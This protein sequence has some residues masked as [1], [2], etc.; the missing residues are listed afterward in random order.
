MFGKKQSNDLRSK[1]AQQ[2]SV[3]F[4]HHAFTVMAT[5]K[6][7]ESSAERIVIRS[8]PRELFLS[9]VQHVMASEKPTAPENLLMTLARA[10]NGLKD[11]FK[12][13]SANTISQ[14]H[15]SLVSVAREY[16]EDCELVH[17]SLLFHNPSV[18]GGWHR[19]ILARIT[20]EYKKY[21]IAKTTIERGAIEATAQAMPVS[22]RPA[23][24]LKP[25]YHLLNE[26]SHFTNSWLG[27]KPKASRPLAWPVMQNQSSEQYGHPL[28][29]V[30]QICCAELP[31]EAR[32]ANQLPESGT[33]YIFAMLAG[34]GSD[35][36]DDD[37]IV[38]YLPHDT[39]P[40][41][42]VEPPIGIM[43]VYDEDYGNP[44]NS[45]GAFQDG[46]T[47]EVL[48]ETP[49]T[50]IPFQSPPLDTSECAQNRRDAI[51]AA[52]GKSTQQEVDT[53][54]Q[55]FKNLTFAVTPD[56]DG[57]IT[58]YWLF[59]D[60]FIDACKRTVSSVLREI[61]PLS[62]THARAK[63]Y[64]Q[65]F[66]AFS[67]LA[68][69]HGP[70]DTVPNRM[71][72]LVHTKWSKVCETFGGLSQKDGDRAPLVWKSACS[73]RIDDHNTADFTW[74]ITEYD[75]LLMH[76]LQRAILQA[77]IDQHNPTLSNSVIDILKLIV[78]PQFHRF[79]LCR[80]PSVDT[81]VYIAQIGGHAAS[82]QDPVQSDNVWTMLFSIAPL[83]Y[84]GIEWGDYGDISILI[85]VQDLEFNK[86][87]NG[88]AVF[89]TH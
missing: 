18:Y 16:G 49:V 10:E 23:I 25:H 50:F 33:L 34:C 89:N 60:A 51:T 29:F 28:T 1:L 12:T 63:Q 26:V 30:A 32:R 5:A 79:S 7:S 75:R 37:I 27:G 54:N 80:Q 83:P 66:D 36:Q 85:K 73:Y 24:L 72:T 45:L 48:P 11:F 74:P 78:G 17:H 46:A 76:R 35:D 68:S 31:N 65:H 69:E 44:F 71:M 64:L 61:D 19:H 41:T 53:C 4:F 86:F 9:I 14:I 22:A 3:D 67:V 55:D 87:S 88:R 8:G 58:A 6:H 82:S 81:D 57:S 56:R 52:L 62:P 42:V 2:V 47:P 40:K 38:R 15:F 39:L 21:Q 43:P 59:M 13:C 70:W 77:Q 84:T 20:S